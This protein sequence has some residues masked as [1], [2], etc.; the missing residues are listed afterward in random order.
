LD[1]PRVY[2]LADDQVLYAG[3]TPGAAV[4]R[5]DTRQARPGSHSL[6]LLVLDREGRRIVDERRVIQ[7]ASS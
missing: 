3:D 6:R 7:V 1:R 5:W 2:I 4:C